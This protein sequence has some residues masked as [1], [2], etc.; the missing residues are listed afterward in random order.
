MSSNQRSRRT[1]GVAV[2]EANN[3][4]SKAEAIPKYTIPPARTEEGGQLTPSLKLKRNMVVRE[5]RVE[6]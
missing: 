1:P 2:D 3:A 4:V 5:A 6:I